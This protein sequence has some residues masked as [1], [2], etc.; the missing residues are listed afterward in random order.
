MKQGIQIIGKQL[1]RIH[2]A[3]D[4]SLRINSTTSGPAGHLGKIPVLQC[5]EESAIT[6]ADIINHH[7]AGRHIDPQCKCLGGKNQ[8]NGTIRKQS[9]HNLFQ[10]GVQPGMMVSHTSLDQK[11]HVRGPLGILNPE[12]VAQAVETIHH[13]FEIR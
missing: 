12:S 7:G 6:L 11:T 4:K 5:A 8:A 9:F 1:M 2:P 13:G 10:H 3:V